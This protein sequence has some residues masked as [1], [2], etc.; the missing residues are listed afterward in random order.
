MS[1]SSSIRRRTPRPSHIAVGAPLVRD[2]GVGR[3]FSWLAVKSTTSVGYRVSAAISRV[4]HTSCV[5]D[6]LAVRK[7]PIKEC[8]A[9]SGDGSPLTISEDDPEDP[10]VTQ[11]LEQVRRAVVKDR[12]L[13]D[14]VSST[15][16]LADSASQSCFRQSKRSYPL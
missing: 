8:P 4:A 11:T 5:P 15:P 10:A 3:G 12:T 7:I 14:K 9:F 13:Y 1:S 2:E 6:F 16:V